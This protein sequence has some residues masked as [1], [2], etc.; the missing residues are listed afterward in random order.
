MTQPY[1][2]ETLAAA[3]SPETAVIVKN[4]PYGF[5]LRCTMRV[6]IE[7][8]RGKGFRYC[9]QTT[10]PKKPGTVWNAPK[11]STYARISMAIGQ[12]VKGHLYPAS[13]SEYSSLEEMGTFWHA[14]GYSL[15]PDARAS[16]DYYRTI[17][18]AYEN[19]CR[20]NGVEN[21]YSATP[22]QRKAVSAAYLPIVAAAHKAGVS[23]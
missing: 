16:L 8:K 9:T 21:I 5:N 12:D 2:P 18:E 11:R 7:F 23:Y 6:W 14:H 17:K 10:N 15:S 1:T 3:V 19:A 22:E 4:Y 20:E 13:L